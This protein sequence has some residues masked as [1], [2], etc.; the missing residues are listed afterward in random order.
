MASARAP[1]TRLPA[2][3]GGVPSP[4]PPC[5]AVS[6][7]FIQGPLT[8][9]WHDSNVLCLQEGAETGMN[10][11]LRRRCTFILVSAPAP[12]HGSAWLQRFMFGHCK[13]NVQPRVLT[14]C[15]PGRLAS[16]TLRRSRDHQST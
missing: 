16:T 7:T 14:P 2:L 8:G 9:Q 3:G 13:K 12:P 6:C 5:R 10:V 11:Q 4:I 15:W 1:G